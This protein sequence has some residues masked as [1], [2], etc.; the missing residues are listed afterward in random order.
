MLPT[1]AAW[2]LPTL[3]QAAQRIDLVRHLNLS[4]AAQRLH[5]L[6]DTLNLLRLYRRFFPAQYA[7][8]RLRKIPRAGEGYSPAERRFFKLVNKHLF[9]L[10]LP[11][12][13]DMY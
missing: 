5:D 4:H 11:A 12:L 8:S 1:T 9:P 3:Q 2:R 7:A 10:A 13:E 6:G